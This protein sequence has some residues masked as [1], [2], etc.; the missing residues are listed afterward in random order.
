MMEIILT[1]KEICLDT[2]LIQCLAFTNSR[3]ML[4]NHDAPDPSEDPTIGRNPEEGG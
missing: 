4:S 1:K 3:V 2:V